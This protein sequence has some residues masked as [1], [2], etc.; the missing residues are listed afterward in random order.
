MADPATADPMP[1]AAP[2][3]APRLADALVNL[4][5][6][7]RVALADLLADPARLKARIAGRGRKPLIVTGV[8]DTWAEPVRADPLGCL[9][10]RA[11]GDSVI[12]VHRTPR[13]QPRRPGAQ[14]T[15]AEF[16]SAVFDRG[17]SARVF[18]LTTGHF[19]ADAVGAYRPPAVLI[20]ALPIRDRYFGIETGMLF[21]GNDAAT[22]MHY[23]REWNDLLH[24]AIAGRR[25]LTLFAPDQSTALH[26]L[27]LISDSALDFDRP[28]PPDTPGID[29]AEGYRC[30]LDPGEMLVLPSR[31]WHFIEYIEPSAAVSYSFYTGRVT[32]LLGTLNGLFYNGFAVVR[33]IH[34]KRWFRRWGRWHARTRARLRYGPPRGPVV[35]ALR[36]A[37]L[38]LTWLAERTVY[39]LLWY[40]MLFFFLARY[41]GGATIYASKT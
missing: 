4:R 35:A 3:G 40:P 1:P 18:G 16:F 23:D 38:G 9:R 20:S 41:R 29:R 27:P 19:P 10:A 25:R 21:L 15:V 11:H 12:S 14:M 26:R 31:Y 5:P 34:E 37:G 17:E 30:E 13:G 2:D 7:E 39:C 33:Q 32:W 6:V 8:A 36:A 28:V 22:D 24:I